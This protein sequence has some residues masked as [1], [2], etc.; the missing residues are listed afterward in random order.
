MTCSPDRLHR[1]WPDTLYALPSLLLLFLCLLYAQ[2]AEAETRNAEVRIG[3]ILFVHGSARIINIR[4]EI[5]TAKAGSFVALGDKVIT[6]AASSLQIQL[7]DTTYFAVRPKSEVVL[8]QYQYLNKP[9]DKVET[10][11]IRGGLRSITGSV[12]DRN[13]RAFRLKTPVATI[14]I[15]GTDL[16]LYYIPQGMP[17]EYGGR[18][19]TYL[20]LQRGRAFLKNEAGTQDV[21][22]GEAA[23]TP[24]ARTAPKPTATLPP[25]FNE[26]TYEKT[27]AGVN[28]QPPAAK[29]VPVTKP[30]PV[31]KPV[32]VQKNNAA[33]RGSILLAA[34]HSGHFMHH[35]ADS[36]PDPDALLLQGIQ[37]TPYDA[38]GHQTRIGLSLDGR[39][40]VNPDAALEAGLAMQNNIVSTGFTDAGDDT[41]VNLSGL[42]WYLAAKIQPTEHLA[43]RGQFEQRDNRGDTDHFYQESDLYRMSKARE[44]NAKNAALYPA[45][46]PGAKTTRLQLAAEL[47]LNPRVTLFGRL[48]QS[49]STW[50]NYYARRFTQ[51]TPGQESNRH[52]DNLNPLHYRAGMNSRILQAGIKARSDAHPVVLFGS[53]LSGSFR[54]DEDPTQDF[55]GDLSGIQGQLI[56]RATPRLTPFAD[57]SLI[58]LT[59]QGRHSAYDDLYD[60]EDGA[61]FSMDGRLTSTTLG[62]GYQWQPNVRLQGQMQYL[63]RDMEA[64]AAGYADN[65]HSMA[66]ELQLQVSF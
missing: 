66:T 25:V 41:S 59:G 64:D 10:S 27:V 48:N 38:S 2:M 32:S 52:S 39:Y 8:D 63:S 12:G 5:R 23:Y 4:G 34:G 37:T 44:N 60:P 35:N 18:S 33:I 40:T 17:N 19:G 30:A 3:Q 22:P 14:G 54:S 26:P 49:D 31:N 55:D 53:L 20:T 24:D 50:D 15:R 61:R 1:R 7:S 11:V 45:S 42:D 43:L 28:D 29:P 9:E 16:T 46:A 6:E 47:M 57:I 51:G 21:A 65:R 58:R 62:V 56:W 36:L 13:K